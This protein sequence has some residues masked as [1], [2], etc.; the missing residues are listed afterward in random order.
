MYIEVAGNKVKSKHQEAETTYEW[1]GGECANRSDMP[2]DR[3]Y[4]V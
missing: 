2:R 4:G 1:Y 3:V